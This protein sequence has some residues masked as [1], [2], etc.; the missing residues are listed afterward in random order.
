MDE[1]DEFGV[2][3]AYKA[4]REEALESFNTGKESSIWAFRKEPV[5]DDLSSLLITYTRDLEGYTY[6][7][8]S[9]PV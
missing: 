3:E 4:R 5:G 2:W 1:I 9:D 7:S 6:E 8:P